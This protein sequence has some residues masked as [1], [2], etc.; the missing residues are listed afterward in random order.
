[1]RSPPVRVASPSPAACGA[2][3]RR[4]GLRRTS[5][6]EASSAPAHVLADADVA[7]AVRDRLDRRFSRAA[8]GSS[9]GPATTHEVAAVLAACARARR[10]RSCPQGGNTGLVGGGVPREGEVVLSL[11]PARPTSARSTARRCRSR[12]ARASRSRALQG[13]R[14]P[15]AST[16]ASTSA[17][18][19]RATVGGARR[20]ATPAARAR[21]ATAR[22]ARASRASRRCSPTAARVERLGR[23]AEGQRGL[24]PPGA[25]HRQR[26]HARRHH[27]RALAAR[28]A[29]AGARRRARAARLGRRRGR[30]CWPSLRTSLP[31][32]EAAEFF[33]DDGL[34][35]V[36]AH[37]GVPAPVAER[38]P[39]YVL[40]E[41]AAET[42]PDRGAG[43]R[44]RAR[45]GR[46]RARRRRHRVTR[47]AVAAAR[48]AHRGDRRR[49]RAAQAR[50]RRPARPAR[51]VPAT[52]AARRRRDG[53]G[54]AA[55]P[56][57]P[58]RR[59]QRARQRARAAADDDSVEDAVLRLVAECG[60]TISAEHGVG[61]AKARWLDLVRTPA[62][63][64][65]DGAIKRA[66]DPTGL[67]NPGVVLVAPEP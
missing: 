3:G 60:G 41:C 2:T 5:L 61:V 63:D 55:D 32:L 30:R 31:S 45:R 48:G 56:V 21:C 65:R 34:D 18:A 46:R 52:R 53:A 28:A 17:R 51:R 19:T 66:L 50:R 64:R 36:L 12:S 10:R 67:L 43:R 39:V 33:L 20:D 37:L 26:G 15:R 44:A 62:R 25:A 13:T 49:G 35:L 11:R 29:P 54:R 24:R 7:R 22:R 9:C 27:A 8:R 6:L 1:M 59:R 42:R 14:A 16:P 4:G 40:V 57:R 38:A 23:P 58:P 47:A